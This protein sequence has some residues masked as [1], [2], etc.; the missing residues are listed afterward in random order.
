VRVFVDTSA[1]YAVLDRDD[2]HHEAAAL[3]W[4]HLVEGRATLV[5][6]NYVLVE[7]TALVQHRLGMDAVRALVESMEPALWVEWV[8][9]EDHAAAQAGVVTANRR[10]LSLVDCASFVVMRRLGLRRAF[11]FDDHFVE[12]G[13]E[14]AG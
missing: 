5:T 2:D 1:L 11:A 8:G 7:V 13:F 6:S 3:A 14:G 10:G 4:R 12:Q 9:R